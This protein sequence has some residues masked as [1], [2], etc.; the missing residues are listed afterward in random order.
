MLSSFQYASYC[1]MQL[2]AGMLLEIYSFRI[3][4]LFASL[5]QGIAMIAFSFSPDI[6]VGIIIRFLSGIIT[7]FP[8]VS[9]LSMVSQLYGN[10]YVGLFSGTTFFV[11]NV[12]LFSLSYFQAFLYEQSGDWRSLYFYFGIFSIIIFMIFLI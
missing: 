11:G 8:F 5:C 7:A 1:C 6:I 9:G 2:V 4:L 10:R 3:M 12:V